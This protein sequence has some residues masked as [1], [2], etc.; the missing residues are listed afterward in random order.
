VS[1]CVAGR[2]RDWIVKVIAAQST[3][4]LKVPA[5]VVGEL[6]ASGPSGSRAPQCSHP[7]PP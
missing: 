5:T 7:N 4:R 3:V 1:R 2:Q 6:A